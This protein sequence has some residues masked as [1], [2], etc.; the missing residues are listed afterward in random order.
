[1]DAFARPVL[2]KC[3]FYQ[4]FYSHKY[5]EAKRCISAKKETYPISVPFS[6]P[7]FPYHQDHWMTL[8]IAN[9]Q[10]SRVW[11]G[12]TRKT[13]KS[14]Y[15]RNGNIRSRRIEHLHDIH[16]NDGLIQSGVAIVDSLLTGT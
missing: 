4:F 16:S 15:Y 11:K 12:K 7:Q 9:I 13:P 8:I 5:R 10:K 3:L 6:L 14:V 2:K 1:M